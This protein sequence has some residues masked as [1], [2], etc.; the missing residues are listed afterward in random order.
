MLIDEASYLDSTV[1]TFAFD[2]ETGTNIV[3]KADF[4]TAANDS[5]LSDSAVTTGP[6]VG[7]LGVY[8]DANFNGLLDSS[9]FDIVAF[10]GEGGSGVIHLVDNGPDDMDSEVGKY[11][12]VQD[13]DFLTTHSATFLFAEIDDSLN[14]TSTLSVQPYSSSSTRFLVQQL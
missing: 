9:D 12:S 7:A 2:V 10:F 6:Y 4:G 3:I 13:F 8:W 5:T 11:A 14:I 1:G